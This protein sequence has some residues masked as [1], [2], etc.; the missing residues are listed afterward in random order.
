VYRVAII[1]IFKQT[2]F[3][4]LSS[5][6]SHNVC[7]MKLAN[8]CSVCVYVTSVYVFADFVSYDV[9]PSFVRTN[10]KQVIVEIK[11]PTTISY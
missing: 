6:I 3:L 10:A 7:D 5:I 8:C 1:R 2:W 4:W 11:L 9:L